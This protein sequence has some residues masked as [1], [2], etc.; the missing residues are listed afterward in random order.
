MLKNGRFIFP[1]QLQYSDSPMIQNRTKT[2][3]DKGELWMKLKYRGNRSIP[4]RPQIV[5]TLEELEY[6]A[7]L[8]DQDHTEQDY[9][10]SNIDE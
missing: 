10:T 3:I 4:D 6:L 8:V 2:M 1:N 9:G 5:F 7:N